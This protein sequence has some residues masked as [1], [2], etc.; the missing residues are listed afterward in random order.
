[1]WWLGA[2]MTRLSDKQDETVFAKPSRRSATLIRGG[3]G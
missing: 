1:M 3:N 2:S